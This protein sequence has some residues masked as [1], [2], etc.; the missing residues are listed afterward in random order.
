VECVD[1]VSR[2]ASSRLRRECCQGFYRSSGG[3][4]RDEPKVELD[5][6]GAIE[7]PGPDPVAVRGLDRG[8]ELEPSEGRAECVRA[9]QERLAFGDE[10]AAPQRGV[11]FVERRPR[12]NVRAGARDCAS[13]SSAARPRASGSVSSRLAA[14]RR[15][16]SAI[17]SRMRSCWSSQSIAYAP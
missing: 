16:S 17:D 5:D 10:R 13:V 3:C 15:A 1:R 12:R 9:P 8:L 11:L 4:D 7:G 6:G 14:S 2:S